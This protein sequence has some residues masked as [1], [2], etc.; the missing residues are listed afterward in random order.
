MLRSIADAGRRRG[1]RSLEFL[2]L[3]AARTG[4]VIG[5]R[6]SEIKDKV[7]IVPTERMKGGREHRV[8]LS[9][10]AL[11]VV[12]IVKT[13]HGGEF[14]AASPLATWRCSRCLGAWNG[15]T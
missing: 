4:E 1:T 15:R 14:L 2:I 8:P 9:A 13:E 12:E 3:T 6:P 5:A 10:P 7:W 11:A